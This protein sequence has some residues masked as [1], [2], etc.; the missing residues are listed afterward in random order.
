MLRTTL[1]LT[2]KKFGF[3]IASGKLNTNVI[4]LLS[5]AIQDIISQYNREVP[6]TE[7][8]IKKYNSL[9]IGT[10]FLAKFANEHT[11]PVTV[12]E[13]NDTKDLSLYDFLEICQIERYTSMPSKEEF[14]KQVIQIGAAVL[15]KKNL[16]LCAH[17]KIFT[18]LGIETD[19][20]LYQNLKLSKK[21]KAAVSAISQFA[22]HYQASQ[23]ENASGAVWQKPI[24]PHRKQQ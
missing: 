16:S 9:I 20:L 12:Y 17:N 5:Y 19:D 23:N 8:M 22:A 7:A 15:D 13:K 14:D 24:I 1:D 2:T 18:E 4:L 6:A 3:A 11:D 21:N 10:I